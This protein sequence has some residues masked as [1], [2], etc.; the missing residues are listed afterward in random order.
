MPHSIHSSTKI[1][2]IAT[3]PFLSA[4]LSVN[5]LWCQVCTFYC[6]LIKMRCNLLP[7]DKDVHIQEQIHQKG[8]NLPLYYYGKFIVELEKIQTRNL[9]VFMVI[10]LWPSSTL[11]FLGFLRFQLMSMSNLFLK[12][13]TF[14]FTTDDFT[15]PLTHVHW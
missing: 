7:E 8:L 1:L 11:K 2:T 5:L 9:T 3:A 15:S 12:F 14:N 6:P 4:L 10:V 13:G